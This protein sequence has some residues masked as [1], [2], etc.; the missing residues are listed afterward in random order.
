MAERREFL[1]S[2]R[3]RP[4]TGAALR[5][6][7]GWR[8]RNGLMRALLPAA[9]L[10]V[11]AA[12]VAWPMLN[13]IEE[14]FSLA[15]R[16]TD[17]AAAGSDQAVNPRFTSTDSSRRPYTVNAERAWRKA[18]DDD[19]IFLVEPEADMAGTGEDRI[20]VTARRGVLDRGLERM[21]LTDGVEVR[22]GSGIELRTESA[23]LDMRSGRAT[24]PDAVSGRGPWGRI[25]ATGCEYSTER[26]VL[27]CGGRP[28]LVLY[29]RAFEGEG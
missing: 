3:G 6:E 28:T 16:D 7:A 1:G 9:A 23:L 12:V 20:T 14:R 21:R 19:R 29:P 24:A 25:D 10:G 13:G 11:A 27:R 2:R 15:P 22:T 8:R 4:D 26:R 17:L 18:A 5:A